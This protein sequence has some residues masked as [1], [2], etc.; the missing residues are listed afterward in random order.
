MKWILFTGTWRLTDKDVEK[1]VRDALRKIFDNGDNLIVGGATGVD[2]F[3]LHE[4]MKNK[5]NLS[6]VRVVIPARLSAYKK[7]YYKNWCT[8]PITKKDIDNLINQLLKLKEISPTSLLELPQKKEITQDDYYKM[9]D[10]LVKYADEVC[11]FQVNNSKGTQDAIDKA[12]SL[13]LKIKSHKK[14]SIIENK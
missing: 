2:Y 12:K 5:K 4:V 13:G 10:E 7:D 11:A 8:S 6:R 14:Y 9:N 1:D 3:A